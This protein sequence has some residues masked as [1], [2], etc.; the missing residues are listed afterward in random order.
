MIRTLTIIGLIIA[1][2][3]PLIDYA[4]LRPKRKALP[5]SRLRAFEALVYLVFLGA[6]LLMTVSSFGMIIVGQAM[7]RWMLVLHMSIAPVFAVCLTLLALMW[8]EQSQIRA[9]DTP[10]ERFYTGEKLGFWVTV[11]AGFMTI[12][13]AM[14][15]MMTWFGS[16]GQ[17]TLLNIHR[18]SALVVVISAVYHGTRLL[19]GRPAAIRE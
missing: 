4:V 5:G 3:L 15:G 6:V 12:T 1:V 10:G 18:I 2:W 7:H 9:V 17:L 8:A 16:D 14:L 11:A 19:L 13:S